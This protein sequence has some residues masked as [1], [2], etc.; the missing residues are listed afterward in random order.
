MVAIQITAAARSVWNTAVINT[1]ADSSVG[2]ME[3]RN[4]LS[5]VHMRTIT[6]NTA[7][8]DRRIVRPAPDGTITECATTV[9]AT[10]TMAPWI[11]SIHGGAMKNAHAVHAP[12]SVTASSHSNVAREKR[13]RSHSC[14]TTISSTRPRM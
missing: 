1:A 11:V 8:G 3:V 10:D 9:I 7:P 13:R 12:N 2:E 14:Q 6:G 4:W 5:E